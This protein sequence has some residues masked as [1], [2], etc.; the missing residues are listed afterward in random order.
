MDGDSGTIVLTRRIALEPELLKV[1]GQLVA[2]ACGHHPVAGIGG[3]ATTWRLVAGWIVRGGDNARVLV[4]EVSATVARI[5]FGRL[6]EIS[7]LKAA[8]HALL[9]RVQR[10]A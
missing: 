1:D 8:G 6:K 10:N 9:I 3:H 2:G 5:G 7:R 4:A